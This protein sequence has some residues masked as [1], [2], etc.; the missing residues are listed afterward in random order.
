MKLL[1]KGLFLIKY[2]KSLAAIAYSKFISALMVLRNR[3]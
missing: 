2:A 1:A 3:I